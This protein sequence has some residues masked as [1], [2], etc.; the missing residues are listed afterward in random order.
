MKYLLQII[1]IYFLFNNFLIAGDLLYNQEAYNNRLKEYQ[2][3][4]IANFNSNSIP[5]QAYLNQAV[6]N[7]TLNSIIENI[8]TNGEFDFNLV[9]LIRILFF[10][11]GE[12]D[13][14]ILS[15]IDT[16]PLQ[17]T[18]NE[19]TRVYWSENHVMMWLSSAWLLKEK[20]GIDK[21]PDI[22]KKLIHDL[23]LKIEY[24]FYEF[25]SSIYFPY[26]LSGLLNLIDF[27]QDQEIRDKAILATNRLLSEILLLVNDKGMLFPATA[28]N[29]RNLY[30]N[31]YD[32]NYSH[33][34]YLLTGLGEKPQKAS[35]AAAFLATSNFNSQKVIES[36]NS[37]EN[38]ILH[39]G[40]PIANIEQI[41]QGF[42]LVDRVVFQWSGGAFF[43]P[44][45]AL[46]TAQ[47]LND[48][49][50]WEHEEFKDFKEFKG[51]PL[52]LAPILSEAASSISYSS[53]NVQADIAIFKDK[54]VT[55]SSIQDFWKGKGAYQQWSWSAAV[56]DIAVTAQTGD[57]S[58]PLE[59]NGINVNSTLPYVQQKDNLAL[60]MYRPHKSLNLFGRKR[61]DIILLWDNEKFDEYL[62]IGK[63]IIG[64]RADSYVGVL[65]HCTDTISGAYACDDQDGQLWACI[66]GNKDMYGSFENFI[67]KI[68][69]SIFLEKWNYVF[70]KSEWHYYGMVEVDGKKI[71]YDWIEGFTE[72]PK[73]PITEPI[74]TSIKNNIIKL[75]LN[76]YPNPTKDL[77]MID[78]SALNI[79]KD[80]NISI[81]NNLGQTVFS[82]KI[83]QPSSL[84][85][86]QVQNF[87][88]G[89]Y[90]VFIETSEGISSQKL[91]I[92]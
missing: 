82:K 60:I 88:S 53:V 79:S 77:I 47:I 68:R 50:L 37:K 43:H 69:H 29:Y 85:E 46:E 75:P 65:R 89:I 42:S 62:E 57:A 40:H 83:S 21:V 6:D 33:L 67:D 12:Y 18:P 52:N 32:R 56:D 11:H 90:I 9:Q 78:L 48:Y 80:I 64:R 92:E 10:T 25:F 91:I 36:W 71:D 15:A 31:T 24:G 58:I 16:I 74:V 66:V 63:W 45:V 59:E 2:E 26:T 38:L 8:P 81:I 55:L 49:N 72:K 73:D 35:H 5:I 34:I 76:I 87:K 20:Y 41:H 23:D 84:Y 7:A 54:G 19:R 14:L 51:I 13:T 17:L 28:R 3:N 4:A 86:V 30:T 27:S 1:I 61:H 70:D 39:N 22:R 44:K